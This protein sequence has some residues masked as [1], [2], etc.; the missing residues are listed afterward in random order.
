MQIA[1]NWKWLGAAALS[2]IT[3]A[4]ALSGCSARENIGVESVCSILCVAPPSGC[5]YKGS[6]TTGPCSKVTCGELVCEPAEPVCA[7]RCVAPP[8]GCHYENAMTTGPCS[9][10]TCGTVVCDESYPSE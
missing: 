10:V 1:R 7:I 4:A 8:P 3:A 5:E 6:L 2:G 9:Q